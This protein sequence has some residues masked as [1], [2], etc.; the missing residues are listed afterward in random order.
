MADKRTKGRK[1]QA[2]PV[3][4]DWLTQ[5]AANVSAKLAPPG[6]YTLSEIAIKLKIGRTAARTLLIVNKADKQKLYHRTS[7]G[8]IILTP[9]Y[10]L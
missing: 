6:W 5:L 10:K 4:G 3:K 2:A 7:D 1:L 9:H 8:R